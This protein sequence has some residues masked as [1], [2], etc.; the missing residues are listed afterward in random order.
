VGVRLREAGGG[1]GLS[2]GKIP[3][4]LLCFKCLR[5]LEWT[6]ADSGDYLVFRCPECGLLVGVR[7]A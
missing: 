3:C 1:E 5:K 7:E 6:G 4:E 2:K